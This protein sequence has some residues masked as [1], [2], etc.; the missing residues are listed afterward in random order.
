MKFIRFMAVL[1]VL[2]FVGCDKKEDKSTSIFSKETN[3]T[4][5]VEPTEP[6]LTTNLNAPITI[7]FTN[8]DL[9]SVTKTDEGMNIENSDKA[10]LFFFFTPWCPPCLVQIEILN[11]LANK[12]ENDIEFYGFI[13]KNDENTSNEDMLNLENIKFRIS[14]S[15]ENETLMD[16]IGGIKNI[17]FMVIYKKDGK[18]YKSYLGIIPEEMLEIEIKKA[19]K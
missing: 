9:I 1:L 12:Y 19:I 2:F 18:E 11:N 14:Q 3:Q 7:K 15:L 13:A 4:L 6:I 16:A 17:P 8:A 10:T 5:E